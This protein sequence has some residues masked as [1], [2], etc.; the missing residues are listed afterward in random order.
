MPLD[1]PVAAVTH[2]DPYPY[3]ARLVADRPL[4]YDAGLACW[5]A[6]SAAAVTLVLSDP[7][8]KVRPGSDPV[9]ATLLGSPAGDLF[10][11]LVRMNDGDLHDSL[12][13]AIVAALATVGD[14]TVEAECRRLAALLL[15]RREEPAALGKSAAFS[16]AFPTH[17]VGS[18]LG[19][20]STGLDRA[21]WWLDDFA[22]CLVPGGIVEALERGKLA[23]IELAS[24][25]RTAVA[26]SA[27][28]ARGTVLR[29]L[30]KDL[31]GSPGA[32]GELVIANCVG[33]LVQA[34]EATAGLIGNVLLAVAHRPALRKHVAADRGL[35]TLLVREVLRYDPPIQNTRRIPCLPWCGAGRDNRRDRNRR[36][37]GV[38]SRNC[39][40]RR[41][42]HLP[43][44]RQCPRPAAVSDDAVGR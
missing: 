25:V 37:S 40:H 1:N 28:M 32:P 24:L 2:P 22:R 10:R 42:R 8:C 38:R 7:S 33:L 3:Y 44:L 39:R 23:A 35:L 5:V 34:Y 27:V 18:L 29:S 6:S 31:N 19:I 17:V 20:P 41:S 30:T 14:A 4:Y 9:P 11:S 16:L 13:R 12:K 26:D 15:A 36:N 43:A 21:V